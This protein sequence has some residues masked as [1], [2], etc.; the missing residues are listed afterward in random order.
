MKEIIPWSGECGRER[1]VSSC[2]S[3]GGVKETD[4][5]KKGNTFNG[6]LSMVV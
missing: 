1:V 4:P 2:L 6:Q 5:P 3:A